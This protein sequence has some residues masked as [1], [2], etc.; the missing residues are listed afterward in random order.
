MISTVS[1][2]CI[3]HEERHEPDL[4]PLNFL[5]FYANK[6]NLYFDILL[7]SSLWLC[8]ESPNN[9][10]LMT[11][12]MYY[13][14]DT[15]NEYYVIMVRLFSPMPFTPARGK[16]TAP[17]SSLSQY[18][19]TTVL[20]AT[21]T[22]HLYCTEAS[23]I[24]LCNL[25]IYLKPFIVPEPKSFAP[26]LSMPKKLVMQFLLIL[27]IPVHSLH[28]LNP[29]TMQD[30][31]HATFLSHTQYEQYTRRRLQTQPVCADTKTKMK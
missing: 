25:T 10:L 23:P 21:T 11:Y 27:H 9:I 22:A 6:T 31:P 4:W 8:L 28:T 29:H 20:S 15:V 12:F 18:L 14:H 24:W 17:P 19:L 1:G 2:L 3:E 16:T 30:A 5:C 26:Q 13:I 7:L